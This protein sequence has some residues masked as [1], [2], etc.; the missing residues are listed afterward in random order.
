LKV[1]L[2]P[3]AEHDL[4]E[5]FEPLL[6]RV[7]KR[8]RLLERFPELGAAMQGPFYGYRSTVVGMFRIIYRTL[9][10]DVLEVAYIRHGRRGPIA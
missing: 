2:L 4:D 7:V 9:P 10:A 8:L 1:V 3:Q 5:I 6:S